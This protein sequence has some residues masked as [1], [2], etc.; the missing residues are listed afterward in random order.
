MNLAIVTKSATTKSGARVPFELAKALKG[1]CNISIFAQEK[2]A[3]KNLKRRYKQSFSAN[4]NLKLYKDFIHLYHL[5]KSDRF[6][7]IS[8]HAT[9]AEMLACKLASKRA[10]IPIVATYYGTQFDAYL[11][12]NLPEEILSPVDLLINKVT[13]MAIWTVKKLQMSLADHII[14]ISE[15][16]QEELKK[17]YGITSTVI[18][19]GTNLKRST[20][21]Q[22]PTTE[23]ITILS[24]SRF[25]P[26]KGFNTLIDAVSKLRSQG[27][28]L[29]LILVG[30]APKKNYLSYLKSKIEAGDE[31]LTNV[32][33]RK[34]ANLYNSCDIYATCDKYLF[35]GLPIVEAANFAKPSIALDFAAASEII[36]NNKTGLIA[37]NQKDLE[38]CIQKLALDKR[39]RQ[40]MGQNAQQ[41]ANSKFNWQQIAKKYYDML[42]SQNVAR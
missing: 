2:N 17:L 24:V 41:L 19:L 25:T 13:N 20:N 16:A 5:L 22:L 18:Y 6:D 36:E 34:L 21:N 38:K 30:S 10:S 4:K 39:L 42:K 37:K 32:D 3:D 9:L 29:K 35:F 27:L 33:D 40:K 8:F 26:Y 11:E 1:K 15:Y 14:S 23:N 28:N 7:V 12:K 31:I